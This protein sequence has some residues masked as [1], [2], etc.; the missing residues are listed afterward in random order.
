LE[1]DELVEGLKERVPKEEDE[2]TVAPHRPL[3][4]SV[5]GVKEK[6]KSAVRRQLWERE[7]EALDRKTT[8]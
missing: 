8:V 1:T 5:T 3:R 2:T 4:L 6:E 7:R